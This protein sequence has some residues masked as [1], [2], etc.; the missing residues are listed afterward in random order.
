MK[1]HDQSVSTNGP[2][3]AAGT[4]ATGLSGSKTT[5]GRPASSDHVELSDVS[6][7]LSGASNQREA[8]LQTIAAAVGNDRYQVDSKVVSRAL[9]QETVAQGTPTAGR[10]P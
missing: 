7:V 3:R 5:P 8:R 9:V 4:E 10:R 2:G 6:R 1:I